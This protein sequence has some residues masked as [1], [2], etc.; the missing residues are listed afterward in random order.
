MKIK[1]IL[2]LLMACVMVFALAAC[3]SGT[4]TTEAPT[5]AANEAGG[6]EAGET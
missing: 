2:A 1:K 4:D 5:T 3:S 6:A